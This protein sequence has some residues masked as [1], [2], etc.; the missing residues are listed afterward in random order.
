M[1]AELGV[2]SV[3][4][5]FADIPEALRLTRPLDL[6]APLTSEAELVRHME[7]LLSA[8]VT[9]RQALNFCGAGCYQ[10]HVPVVC[11]E[12]NGRAE[13]LTA[14]AGETYEDHGKFQALFE[15]ASMMAELLEM[16]VVTIPTYDGFQAAATALRMATRITHRSGLVVVGPVGQDK[17][18]KVYDYVAPVATV[19]HLSADPVVPVPLAEIARHVGEDT[20]AV[21]VELPDAHG[22]VDADL[23]AL[24]A[25]AHNVGALLVVGVDPI[26]LGVLD[27]PSAAGADIVCGDIQSLGLG[28]QAGGAHGGFLAVHDDPRFV[29]ELPSRLFGL[30]PTGKPGEIGFRDVAYERT[31][32][33][34]RENGNE[35]VGT[36]AA[37][38]GITAGVYLALHGPQGM[39]ELGDTII[40]RTHYAMQT[41]AGTGLVEV[42][43]IDRPH[44]REFVVDLAPSGRTAADFLKA[45]AQRRIFAGVD[46]S[47]ESG[48]QQVL[49]CTTEV[50]NQ[51]D[52]DT[53]VAAVKEVLA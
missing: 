25:L 39:A 16:D 4:E 12:V 53:L 38:W 9:T 10:H 1:L 50:H 5:F 35:W 19:E 33:A 24:A 8:N 2:N 48:S 29:L 44:F 26:A 20:A 51:R 3:D 47:A 36:A 6:P 7:S 13:F 32:L 14:Y 27:P 34:A 15:Y 28:M 43:G 45:M 40:D 42:P 18:S 11:S 31:S 37:L 52:I 46:I 41:L 22:C 17:L 23:G 49:L 30:T 21:Y